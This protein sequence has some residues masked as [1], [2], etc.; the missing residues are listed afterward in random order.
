MKKLLVSIIIVAGLIALGVAG[1]NFSTRNR[2]AT[3]AAPA[4]AKQLWTCG[5]HPQIIQDHPGPCPICGMP[6]VPLVTELPKGELIRPVGS[7]P[8]VVIDPTVVQNMGI[9]TALVTRG[10]LTQTVR[11]VAMLEIP[12][13]A[14]YDVNLRINGW[15]EKLYADQEGILVRAGQPLFDFYSPDLQVA[16][17]ELISATAALKTR[18]GAP[19]EARN[20]VNSARRKLRLW[21]IADQDIQ[22]IADS[23]TPP[24]TVPIRSP[25]DGEL[26]EKMIAQGAGVQAG[27]TL[28][29]IE[30]HSKLWLTAQVYERQMGMVKV[31]QTAEATFDSMPGQIFRGPIDF[32]YPHLDPDTRTAMVRVTLENHH[33]D[34]KPGMYA[35]VNILTRPLENVLLAP[36]EAVIDTGTRQVAFVVLS[37]GHFEPRNVRMGLVGDDDRV[38]ILDGLNEGETVVTSGQFLLDVNSRTNEAL[39]KLEGVTAK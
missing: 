23:A 22:T 34:L 12:Q 33:H 19:A 3:A 14:E 13:T 25:V 30:D 17:E 26:Q 7:A 27:T 2:G 21:G 8:A 15:I 1:W 16:E 39:L 32:I 18:D 28:M 6:L 29:R 35:T 38:Q 31:G 11:V 5:M 24:E 36:R 10:T 37:Q 9:R 4:T 20:L